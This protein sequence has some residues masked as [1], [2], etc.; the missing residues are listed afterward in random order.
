MPCQSCGACCASSWV[1]FH[2]SERDDVAGGFV[3][4]GLAVDETS[5]LCR[6]RGTDH[7]PPRC[8]ALK[9]V[10]GKSVACSIYE[11]RPS[12][13]RDFQPHGVF[14]VSNEDC[15]DARARH[16]LSPLPGPYFK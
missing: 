7:Y 4:S 14:R 13:C 2:R 6:M 16:G 12:P 3:P 10:I 5:S 1:T 8:V 11:Y 9:G 15:N